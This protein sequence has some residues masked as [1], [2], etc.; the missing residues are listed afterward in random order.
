MQS[1]D[2]NFRSG[3]VIFY[4]RSGIFRRAWHRVD[5]PQADVPEHLSVTGFPAAHR[6]RSRAGSGLAVDKIQ[7]KRLTRIA[8]LFSGPAWE[9][10]PHSSGEHRPCWLRVNAINRHV[11]EMQRPDRTSSIPEQ[12]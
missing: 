8:S 7:L 5:G 3:R 9:L 2:L 11:F 4:I 6:R 10:V 1:R 12:W